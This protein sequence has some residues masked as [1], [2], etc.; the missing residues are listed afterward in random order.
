MLRILVLSVLALGTASGAH[1]D[2]A[3]SNTLV[4]KV[5]TR[6]VDFTDHDQTG[7]FYKHLKTVA[8]AVCDVPGDSFDVRGSNQVCEDEAMDDA[9]ETSHIEALR[10]WHDQETGHR[11]ADVASTG[12]SRWGR[13]GSQLTH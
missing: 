13:D 7:R 4:A 10:R 9:V 1:A 3:D 5:S 12:P 2:P 8:Q 6:G 11:Q